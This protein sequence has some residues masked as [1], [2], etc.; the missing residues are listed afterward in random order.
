MPGA[1][2]TA[3]L[4]ELARALLAA[5]RVPIFSRAPVVEGSPPEV[6]TFN[7][8][9]DALEVELGLARGPDPSAWAQRWLARD[10]AA[11]TGDGLAALPA[12]AR[13]ALSTLWVEAADVFYVPQ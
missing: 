9:L 10:G 7:A 6:E 4:E 1:L 8:R 13:D 12:E 3:P 5:G 2:A 11:S